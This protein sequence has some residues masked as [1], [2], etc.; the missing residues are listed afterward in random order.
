MI[1]ERALEKLREA[2]G[3]TLPR[4]A[5]GSGGAAAAAAAAASPVA[6]GEYKS[7]EA[8]K[9]RRRARAREVTP[10]GPAP[11][12]LQI[13]CD[14]EHA[15]VHRILTPDTNFAA[16]EQVG[17]AYRIIRT[18]LLNKVRTHNWHSVAITSP[19][20]GE[21]KSVTAMNLA[22]NLA[23]D[24]TSNVY[25][26]DL[27]MRNPTICRNLGVRPPQDLKDYFAGQIEAEQI[28]F[29]IGLPNLAI[30]GNE[31]GTEMASELLGNNRLEQLIA[32][33]KS[34]APSPLIILDM[35]PVLVTDEALL[36]APRVDAMILVVAEGK[37]R[38]ESLLRARQQLAD[39]PSAGVILNKSSESMGNAGYYYGYGYG[40]QQP[41]K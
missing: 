20:A 19:E 25:L 38:R 17:A 5:L 27:D 22:L 30:C 31:S 11:Q 34:V 2:N 23:R 36:V 37:T 26:I 16:N 7:P 15:R 1:I 13:A 12:Y 35:P 28:F 29:S 14:W 39:Y 6:T 21:G 40:A 3:G 9:E 4:D 10:A 18:R 33:I 24:G 8:A 41:D 32:H